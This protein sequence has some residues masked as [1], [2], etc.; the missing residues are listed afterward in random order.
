MPNDTREALLDAATRLFASAGFHGA[1]LANIADALGL[2][3]QAL[4]HHFGTK[5]KL[6]G[7]VLA[8]I[9]ERM[10]AVVASAREREDTPGAQLEAALL[11]LYSMSL[12]HPDGS[13]IIVREVLD[14]DRR[15]D[16][17]RHWYLKPF[18]D[19]LV[20]I[21]RDIPAPRRV[22]RREAMAL[23]YPLLGA[24]D[25]LLVCG[26]V[27]R[28]MYGTATYRHMTRR[29]PDQIRDQVRDLIDRLNDGDG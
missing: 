11:D 12:A 19:A 6:Y 2:T 10:E 21:V 18:L 8:R 29:Y 14:I 26:P 9:A 22:S 25:Y 17:I 7:E 1:S 5:E 13:R 20:N 4:L 24:M 23:A 28:G 15:G 16:D 27:L 3:K